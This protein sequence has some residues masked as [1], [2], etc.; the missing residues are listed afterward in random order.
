MARARAVPELPEEPPAAP[1]ASQPS[2]VHL[3]RGDGLEVDLSG[4]GAFVTTM[5]ERLLVALGMVAPPT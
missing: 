2:H 3:R 4:D 5:L 1:A